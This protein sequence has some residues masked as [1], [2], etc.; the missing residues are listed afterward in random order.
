MYKY[1]ILVLCT[2]II[3]QIISSLNFHLWITIFYYKA[4]LENYTFEVTDISLL[5]L[6]NFARCVSLIFMKNTTHLYLLSSFDGGI[7]SP[8]SEPD[9]ICYTQCLKNLDQILV[10]N[11]NIH[12][13]PLFRRNLVLFSFHFH[14]FVIGKFKAF[15]CLRH[16]THLHVC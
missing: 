14:L 2:C 7:L 13:V 1:W 11:I 16:T 6:A 12:Y 5:R 3:N 9:S 8:H 10:N 15:H 4:N